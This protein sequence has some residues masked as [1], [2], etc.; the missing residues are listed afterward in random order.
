MRG[1]VLVNLSSTSGTS[2]GSGIYQVEKSGLELPFLNLP[3][4]D[5]T[6]RIES[7]DRIIIPSYTLGVNVPVPDSY[8]NDDRR[9]DA[10]EI[11]IGV[12]QNRSLHIAGDE[13]YAFFDLADSA[14][15]RIES[16]SS[17]GDTGLVLTDAG[18]TELASTLDG[19]TLA[20]RLEIQGLPAGRYVVRVASR[21]IPR[22][23]ANYQLAVEVL[24]PDAYEPDDRPDAAPT[25][26][27]DVAMERSFHSSGD[28]DHAVF[29]LTE[30]SRVIIE[31]AGRS[32]DTVL[33]LRDASGQLIG[34]NDDHGGSLFSRI[35]TL[36][37][38]GSYLIHCYEFGNNGTIPSYELR[39]AVTPEDAIDVFVRRL[40]RRYLER[41]PTAG[42]L[43]FWSAPLRDGRETA[44]SLTRGIIMSGESNRRG[45]S[46]R[47]FVIE[48]YQGLLGRSPSEDE[49]RPTLV[50]LDRGVLRED[51]LYG[52]LYAPE[53]ADVSQAAGI[54]LLSAV[55]QQRY[56]VHQ[57]VRRFFTIAYEAEPDVDSMFLWREALIEGRQ[58][59]NRM[60]REILT[61]AKYTS[62]AISDAAFIQA[63]YPLFLNRASDTTGLTT[64][65]DQLERGISRSTIIDRFA[66]STEF[67]DF[68]R[69]LGV[70]TFWLSG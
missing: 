19:S 15:V 29:T 13:D 43:D 34:G 44:F 6:V 59:V 20:P 63:L 8:E 24:N 54:T 22:P 23:V 51:A 30:P 66:R 57:F 39:L 69:N 2:F 50:H 58:P 65:V 28:Q 37:P 16:L 47:A 36:L 55:D 68:A 38:A 27:P 11:P 4:D 33:W 53:F 40:Y 48:L 14:T 45:I 26:S 56:E 21:S 32:G 46:N 12:V 62:Q 10:K 61:N 31:S 70:I 5:Y 67:G 25:I 42:E 18:G 35:E 17:S 52:F 1:R 64:W 9:E 3:A 49:I 60:A 41:S 7:P